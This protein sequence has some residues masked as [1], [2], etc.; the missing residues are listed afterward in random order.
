MQ[1]IGRIKIEMMLEMS[2]TEPGH[3]EMATPIVCRKVDVSLQFCID[4]QKEK[5]LTVRNSCRTPRMDEYA[6]NVNEATIL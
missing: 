3:T 4:Y 1:D 6:D 2:T 5:G